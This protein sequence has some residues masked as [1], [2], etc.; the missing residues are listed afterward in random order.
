VGRLSAVSVDPMSVDDLTAV[1][2][3]EALAVAQPWPLS[4]YQRDLETNRS[5][6]YCVARAPG[7]TP[8]ACPTD[9]ARVVG[10]GGMWIQVDEAHITM[11]A[12]HPRFRRRRVGE[13]LLVRM[14]EEALARRA[15]VVTLEV[16]VS[17]LAGFR[18]Y[19]KYGFVEVGRRR[20]YYADTGEDGLIMTTPDLDDPTWRVRFDRLAGA[21]GLA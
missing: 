16:R 9:A 5:A 15:E 18:L 17:N 3:I 12:V 13:V 6:W 2:G 4:A 8:T 14:I 7:P 11:I 21:L 10:F 19:R 1:V 20:G